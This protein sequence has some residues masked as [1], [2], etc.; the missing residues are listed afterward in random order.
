MD[1]SC[2]GT[3]RM[4]VGALLAIVAGSP[5][6]ASGQAPL[7][8][9][10]DVLKVT[11]E[12]D[13]K[14]LRGDRDEENEERLGRILW[15]ADDGSERSAE[16]QV[17][18]RGNFRLNRKNCRMPPLRLNFK[19]GAMEGTPF[20]GQDKLK[21]V[22]YC[23][24]NDKYEQNVAEEYLVYRLYNQVTDES[25][26][27]RP[28]QLTYVDTSGDDDPLTRFAFLIESEEALAERLG[29]R[30]V[31]IPAAHPSAYP[32]P[33]TP[34]LAIF[35]FMVGN[36]DWS[37]VRFHNVKLFQRA[38]GTAVPVPYDF[39][40]SGVVSAPYAR[41]DESLGTRNVRQRLYRGF[42]RDGVD[43]AELYAGFREL[44]PRFREVIASAPLLDED[45]RK[46]IGEYLD[47]F[48]EVIGDEGKARRNIE[49]SCRPMS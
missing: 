34:K 15:T 42:C 27:V 43:F 45:N 10:D 39:D 38:D 4:W 48:Y 47:D 44:E 30:M 35:Q 6:A 18:T 37:M 32:T 11:L 21:L 26:Q 46:K 40:W 31:E 3:G 14:A 2:T 9:S 20:A 41:P 28:L 23:R 36:T 16:L 25:F 17:R 19:T 5:A 8:Q 1:G 33:E 22:T 13:F 29:G 49:S 12:A 7:F 24:D